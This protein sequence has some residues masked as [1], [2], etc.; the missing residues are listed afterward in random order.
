MKKIILERRVVNTFSGKTP[1]I[2][3]GLSIQGMYPYYKEVTIYFLKW[4]FTIGYDWE[5]E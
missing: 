1:W 3:F 5:T 2:L 4:E